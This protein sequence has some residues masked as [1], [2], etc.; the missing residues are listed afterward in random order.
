MF[1]A[2]E[3]SH[4]RRLKGGNWWASDHVRNA[5]G[6][7]ETVFYFSVSYQMLLIC[8]NRYVAV[9]HW[10]Y[11]NELFRARNSVIIIGSITLLA[12]LIS[13]AHWYCECQI[14]MITI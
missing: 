14:G 3:T 11:Y 8:I 7:L 5:V 9:A 4:T 13:T 6:W 10:R 2:F 12:I 1:K